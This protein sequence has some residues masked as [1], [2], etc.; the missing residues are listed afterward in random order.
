MQTHTNTVLFF[1]HPVL[2]LTSC[3]LLPF[4]CHSAAAVAFL[5]QVS[6]L[7]ASPKFDQP[8][9]PADNACCVLLVS[10]N[11]ILTP[12]QPHGVNTQSKK[13]LSSMYFISRYNM[14]TLCPPRHFMSPSTF[15]CPWHGSP[16]IRQ[17]QGT[18]MH[19]GR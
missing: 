18:S 10:I 8:G 5:A 16:S 14:S 7:V 2:V 15:Y 9:L 12:Q 19:A 3:P 17:Q 13:L 11:C 6:R 4:P 1:S